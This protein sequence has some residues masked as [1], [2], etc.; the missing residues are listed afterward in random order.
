MGRVRTKG[1]KKEFDRV[2]RS[3]DGIYISM[4][5]YVDLSYE[6][7]YENPLHPL[8]AIKIIELSFMNIIS[9]WEEFVQGVYI[10]NFD[11]TVLRV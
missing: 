10:C 3:A 9:A 11:F 6:G 7:I 2:L 1:I 8:Q 5:P 4:L